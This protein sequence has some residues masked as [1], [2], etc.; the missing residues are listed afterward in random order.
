MWDQLPDLG[1]SE[2]TF[3]N[4][5]VIM[6]GVASYLHR[7][8]WIKH[9]TCYSETPEEYYL[10]S[11]MLTEQI[12]DSVV[13]DFFA[14]NIGETISTDEIKSLFDAA[15]GQGAGSK[16][17]VKCSNGLITELW[18]N[19]Q[20]EIDDNTQLESLLKHAEKASSSCSEGVVD[21]VGY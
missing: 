16:V 13:R 5:M 4:L 14:D 6:P 11:M 12:N 2:E 20:G 15:F 3:G 1:L 9:G 17:R 7:H 19:L 10:E 18:I 8:E 21:P